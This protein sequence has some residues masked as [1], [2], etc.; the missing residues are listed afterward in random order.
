MT[1]HKS[2]HSNLGLSIQEIRTAITHLK[3]TGEITTQGTNNHTIISVCNYDDYSY[4]DEDGATNKTTSHA[5]NEQQTNN[6][7]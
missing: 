4:Y 5:T 7:N 6:N 2:L 3:S 1:S